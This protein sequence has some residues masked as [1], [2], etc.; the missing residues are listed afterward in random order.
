MR[1]RICYVRRQPAAECRGVV[2]LGNVCLFLSELF[3]LSRVLCLL[4]YANEYVRGKVLP[5]VIP[6]RVEVATRANLSIP[7][8]AR[9]PVK[10][11]VSSR[12]KKQ[13]LI[14]LRQPCLRKDIL[15]IRRGPRETDPAF[16]VRYRFNL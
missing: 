13:S 8:L 11:H 1:L 16:R 15:L 4:R 14:K 5:I 7:T 10:N 12:N 3:T 9:L 6:S 2:D